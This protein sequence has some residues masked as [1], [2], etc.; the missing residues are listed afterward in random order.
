V[1]E[2]TKLN[3]LFNIQ[4]EQLLADRL[5]VLLVEDLAVG[6]IDDGHIADVFHF[7][8]PATGWS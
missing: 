1:F 7:E 3:K 8:A 2:I 4:A 5:D 6:E